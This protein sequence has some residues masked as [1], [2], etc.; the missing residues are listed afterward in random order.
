MVEIQVP[1]L[2]YEK[3]LF[4]NSIFT[5]NLMF[6]VYYAN[7]FE[8]CFLVDRFLNFLRVLYRNQEE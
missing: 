1:C 8:K 6:N 4:T 3:Q 7:G 2:S 5:S